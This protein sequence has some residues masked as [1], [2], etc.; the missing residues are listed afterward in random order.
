MI[1][2][3]TPLISYLI[4]SQA[5]QEEKE[6][7]RR[8][9]KEAEEWPERLKEYE[10]RAVEAQERAKKAEVNAYYEAL[11]KERARRVPPGCVRDRYGTIYER[12]PNGFGRREL[13]SPPDEPFWLERDR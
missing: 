8:R 7:K 4:V 6:H 10:A 12:N 3:L 5:R 13:G 1:D 11:A 9:Q 2:L